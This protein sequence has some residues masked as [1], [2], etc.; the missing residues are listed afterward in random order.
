MNVYNEY[1][2]GRDD[3]SEP[4]LESNGTGENAKPEEASA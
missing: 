3:S 2:K 1:V 4:R